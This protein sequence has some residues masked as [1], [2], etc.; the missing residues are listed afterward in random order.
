MFHTRVSVRAKLWLGASVATLI[1]FGGIGAAYAADDATPIETVV[2]TGFRGSLDRALDMKRGALDSSDSILAEDIAKF[3]D[4]NLSESIQRIPGVALARDEGEGKNIQVRGLN[5]TFT[6]VRINGMEAMSTTGAEDSQGGTNRG[7]SF[8]FNVFASDLFSAITVHKS[9]SA[10]LEE[11]SL[12]ATV[13]LRTAHPFDHD[14]FT[15]ALSAQGGFAEQGG[16]FN[17]RMSGLISDTFFGDTVG[18]LFSFAVGTRDTLQLGFD[19]TRFENDNTAQNAAHSSPLIAGCG[20]VVG[21]Q[22]QCTAAQRFGSVA[23]NGTNLPGTLATQGSQVGPNQPASATLPARQTSGALLGVA[24]GNPN[25]LPNNYD[26][27]N[28]AFGPRFPRYDLI[29]NHEKRLGFTGSLQWQPDNNTLFTLDV[30][31]SDFAVQRQEE[32]LEA[33]SLS[34]NGTGS[35][36]AV[37]GTPALLAS[38]LAR[39]NVNILSYNL[40]QTTNNL[41]AFTATN[42]GLRAEHRLDHLDTRFGQATLDVTH[43]FSDDLKVHGII[44]WSESHHNNP[45]QT[46]L[47]MDYDCTAATAGGSVANC[48]GGQGGGAGSL[49]A[50]FTVDF[51]GSTKTPLLNFGNVDPT[52]TTGWFLSQIRERTAAVYNSFRTVAADGEYDPYSWLKI[53]AGFD[54]RSYGNRQAATARSNGANTSLDSWIPAAIENTPLSQYTQLVSIKGLSGVPAGVAT[55]YLVPDISKANALFHIFDQTVDPAVLPTSAG[56]CAVAPGC[57]AFMQGISSF[58]ASNGTVQESDQGGWL[59]VGWDSLFYGVPFRG[60]IGGRY[61]VTTTDAS[62]I[63]FSTTTKT[64]VPTE[65]KATYH[66]FLPSLNAVF[67]PVDDFLIRFNASQVMTRPSL[68]ALLPGVTIS[69]SGANPVSV[70]SGNPNLAPYRAKTADLSFEW[71]YHKGALFSVAFFY[72]HLDNIETGLNQSGAFATNPLGIPSSVLLA[73]CGGTFT[74]NCNDTNANTT[75]VTTVTQKGGPLYGTEI[76][77]QQPFDFL[78]DPFSN[79]GLLANVTFV[80]A[81]QHYFLNAAN[82]SQV[83]T[84]DLTGLSRTTYNATLYYDDSVFEARL[85]AAFRSK[86]L[87]TQGPTTGLSINDSQVQAS[88]FNL[89]ASTSYKVDENFSIDFQAL[90]LTNQGLYQ[91]NDTVGKRPLAYYTTGR[92]FFAGVRYNY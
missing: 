89:D 81:Q 39:G 52:S 74:A 19:T 55:S 44:G 56:A 92:E 15:L 69:Q 73:F 86:F 18:A 42:V 80:Q 5:S 40:D 68:T 58:G 35:N 37:S 36:L 64:F 30:L 91:Y 65:V 76:D 23:Y 49:A 2:V 57:G 22:F 4:L 90:N 9:A 7:R 77:W 34:L 6:R 31:A 54:F 8:D 20:T 59:Q 72:K 79:M 82:P 78:P 75:Y 11:G 13:D 21:A 26:V 61:V 62:G 84:A 3:P 71:Y 32:Y 50:P 70:T 25:N 63:G 46:T 87:V 85:S 10:D 27:V 60:N 66:D 12:G 33:N 1:T 28:E 29:P 16:E 47:T 17:P 14:G 43:S 53:T 48:G 38:T 88:T 83:T 67:E 45:I 51:T 41:L 24:N